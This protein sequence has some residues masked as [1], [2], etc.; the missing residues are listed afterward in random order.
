MD[1]ELNIRDDDRH[2]SCAC[3]W[4]TAKREGERFTE[5]ELQQIRAEHSPSD[6]ETWA[7]QVVPHVG[8]AQSAMVIAGRKAKAKK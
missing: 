1:H 3:G 5:A 8:A 6:E 2:A 7:G 4:S